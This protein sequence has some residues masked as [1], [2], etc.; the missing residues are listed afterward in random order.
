MAW[1][2]HGLE[3]VPGSV[4]KSQRIVRPFTEPF[5]ADLGG[6]ASAL[7]PLA[8]QR[9]GGKAEPLP[10]SE[11]A[12]ATRLASLPE[13]RPEGSRFHGV[14]VRPT[15]PAA[16][17]L[18][19]VAKGR[20]EVLEKALELAD[21]VAAQNS[22]HSRPEVCWYSRQRTIRFPRIWIQTVP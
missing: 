3:T 15:V 5:E 4:F 12:R 18:R 17:T 21:Y 8:L 19:G 13:A 6:G 14:G 16:R 10:V 22:S 9:D 2:H 11:D 1:E 20:D 7:V